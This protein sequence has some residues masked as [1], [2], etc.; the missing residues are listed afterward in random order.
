MVKLTINICAKFNY[1][2]IDIIIIIIIIIINLCD[3]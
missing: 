2:I 3:V 1:A